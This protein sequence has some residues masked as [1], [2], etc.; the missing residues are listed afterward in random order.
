MIA[1]V[2]LGGSHVSATRIDPATWTARD[3]APPAW[4]VD[5]QATVRDLIEALTVAARSAQPLTGTPLCLAVPGP[6]DYAGGVGRYAGVGKFTTLNG[7]DVRAA[8]A[9]ALD[10]QPA[11]IT[12]VNDAEAFAVGEWV[13]GA[14]R[15]LDRIAGITLG[16]GVGSA[17][18]DRGRAV[19]DGPAVPPEGRADLLEIDGRP[20]EETVSTRAVL[21]AHGRQA[22]GVLEVIRAGDA[23]ALTAY[24]RLGRALAPYVRDFAARA[25][26]V[27]GAVT[28]S[29]DVIG[30]LFIAGLADGGAQVEVLVAAHPRTAAHVGAAWLTRR[31]TAP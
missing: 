21:R 4:R 3:D 16:T 5:P 15:G 12:F 25:V 20:L 22:A 30:P 31:E 14:G 27:G 17:F 28:R 2:E 26:V 24:R 23:G 1:A 8:L 19:R 7:V 29:W 10:G 9:E 18:L 13:A 6:F 11:E